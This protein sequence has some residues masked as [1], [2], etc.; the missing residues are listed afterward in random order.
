[1]PDYPQPHISRQVTALIRVYFRDERQN[2]KGFLT[3]WRFLSPDL[4]PCNFWLWG[5][6]KDHGYRGNIQTV[7]EMKASIIRHVSSTDLKTLRA[8]VEDIIEVN[9]TDIEQICD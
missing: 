5:F 4:N 8:T 1:M 9:G 3:A 2:S 7:P 6:L